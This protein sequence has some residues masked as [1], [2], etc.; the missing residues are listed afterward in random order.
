[1]KKIFSL[2]LVFAL[3]FA[4]LV[5]CGSSDDKAGTD[6]N[7]KKDD[8]SLVVSGST[9]DINYL[10]ANGGAVYRI[11][12]PDGDAVATPIAQ[13]LLKQFKAIDVSMRSVAD[14]EDGTDTYE[15]LVGST[16]RQETATVRE[17]LAQKT[18]GRYDDYII[19][20]IG[21]KIVI[22]SKSETGLNN[23]CDY[24]IK[25]YIKKEGIK[26]GIEYTFAVKGDFED[27][28]INGAPI[29]SFSFVR[30]HYNSSYLTEV[31]MKTVAENVLARS[32]CYLEILHDTKAAPAKH[33]IIVGNASRDGVEAVGDP[34][35]FTIKI[36]GTKVYLN[37]GS[38]HATAM[39]VT[40]FS[41]MLKGDLTDGEYNG[42]YS[43][44]VSTYDNSNYYAKTWGDDFDGAGLDTSKWGQVTETDSAPGK[45]GKLSVR[46]GDPR[47][48]YVAD[49]KFTIAAREDE[50]Y[51]YGGMIW[52]SGKM[53]YKYGYLEMS[54]LLPHGEGYWVALWTWSNDPQSSDGTG[55]ILSRPEIDIVEM[56][57]NSKYYAA[58][59]HAWPTPDGEKLGFQHTSLDNTHGNDKKYNIP[60]ADKVLGDDFHTYGF[61]WTDTMMGFT[62]DGDLYFS[63]DTTTSPQDAE[64]FN[65]MMYLRISMAYNW[66]SAPY[67]GVSGDPADWVDTNKYI[68]D[69][70]N[71]YQ[72]E[73]QKSIMHCGPMSTF[74]G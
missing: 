34:D 38:A 56:F 9:A 11:V 46:S 63:Y 29:G 12:R 61:L 73:D 33:E 50:N 2:L 21:K 42:S 36:S 52:T 35:A 20:T 67:S 15:I 23:A 37:G 65:H 14:V 30:P 19:C 66:E 62:C 74:Y 32:G 17:M 6:G 41:K 57:G 60:D 39:A 7:E 64:A 8:V 72:L 58:N 24:F 47:D 45:G 43:D 49:G 40:E 59:C 5:G 16:N 1:M 26:G 13:N 71:I 68:V 48:V 28:T 3:S 55:P 4:M 31:E 54:A 27:I 22:F 51:Y 25:N 69:W 18:G 70:I 53:Y 10:D 44:T